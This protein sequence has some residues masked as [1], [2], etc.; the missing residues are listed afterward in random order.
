MCTTRTFAKRPRHPTATDTVAFTANPSNLA[1][2]PLEHQA[3]L[4]NCMPRR[5]ERQTAFAVTRTQCN[6]NCSHRHPRKSADK[7]QRRLLSSRISTKSTTGAGLIRQP[8]THL[9]PQVDSLE[10][11]RRHRALRLQ[12]LVSQTF[13]WYGATTVLMLSFYLRTPR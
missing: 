9:F 11:K 10:L 5:Q 4:A 7:R 13:A 3:L 1:R 2:H 8:Q 6:G 12:F